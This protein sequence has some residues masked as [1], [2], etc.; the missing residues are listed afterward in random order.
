MGER[1]HVDVSRRI[2]PR[3][4]GRIY[5]PFLVKNAKVITAGERMV[6]LAIDDHPYS[7]PAFKY[8]A[9]CFHEIAQRW[10]ALAE[11]GRAGPSPLLS[12]TGCRTDLKGGDAWGGGNC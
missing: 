5:L 8:Q 6:D 9:K 12:E 10:S 2:E 11:S 1:R 7:Q 3:M 4:I